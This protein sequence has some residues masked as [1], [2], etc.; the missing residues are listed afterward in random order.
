MTS[1]PTLYRW[2]PRPI[3]TQL[4]GDRERFGLDI[5]PDDPEWIEWLSTYETFYS[6]TQKRSLGARVNDAG[7]RILASTPMESLR[8]LEIGPG[9]LPHTRF[10]SGRPASYCVADVDAQFLE[11][12]L[13][14]LNREGIPAEAR[15]VNR[16]S[17]LPFADNSFDLILSFYSLE[18]I[19]NPE[20]YLTEVRRVLAPGGRLA[21]AIPAEGG[22]AWGLGRW[23]TTRR[24]L[25]RHTS[26]NPDKIICWEHP[27][28]A[29]DILRQCDQLFA[30]EH[31][32]FWPFGI[33][34]IDPNLV[35]RFR[36]RKPERSH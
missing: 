32:S 9:H 35:V 21:G 28:F 13:A 6:S 26:I 7:Y 18:H 11:S 10:W 25:H 31:L 36:Y 16:D 14:R 3:R 30:K 22:L 20:P 4:F 5:H 29:A 33:R 15:L 17:S 1:Y 12:S 2:I 8:V 34:L 19:R 24:W 27:S 23:L